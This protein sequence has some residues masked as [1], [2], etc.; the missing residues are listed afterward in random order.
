MK[1]IKGLTAGL[2]IAIHDEA[3]VEFGGLGG[4]RDDGLLE[5]AIDRPRNRKAYKP[6]STIFPLAAALCHGLT[7][8]RSFIDGNKRT[9]LLATRLFL[10]LNGRNLN[11]EEAD[12]V[13]TMLA[14]ADGRLSEAVLARWLEANSAAARSRRP[15]K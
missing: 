14:L 12:E 6:R 2:V 8:N 4:I 9:A 13:A 3:I 7:K 5:S 10:H 1:R 15:T 11:P